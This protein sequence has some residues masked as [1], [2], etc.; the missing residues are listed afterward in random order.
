M[1]TVETVKF[2]YIQLCVS[3]CYECIRI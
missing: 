2:L 1:D 3:L